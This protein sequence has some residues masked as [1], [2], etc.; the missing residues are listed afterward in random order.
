MDDPV[1]WLHPPM[2]Q[3]TGTLTETTPLLLQ[4]LSR[5][6]RPQTLPP[7]QPP[8]PLASSLALTSTRGRAAVVSSEVTFQRSGSGAWRKGATAGLT[9]FAA[10]SNDLCDTVYG[11][12]INGP[13]RPRWWASAA[14]L[15]CRAGPPSPCLLLGE[16][17]TQRTRYHLIETWR[18]DP[19]FCTVVP[20]HCT[21]LVTGKKHHS[22]MDSFPDVHRLGTRLVFFP[23]CKGAS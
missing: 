14:H 11:L 20:T 15:P 1:S 13:Q 16:C 8:L 23:S 9:N 17:P 18:H 3:H 5:E 21:L 19:F 10:A 12:T 4:V 7:P 22:Y 2:H 6:E